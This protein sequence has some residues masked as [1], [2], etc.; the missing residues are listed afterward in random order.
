MTKNKK[1]PTR[2]TMEIYE[3]ARKMS[4]ELLNELN[5]IKPKC[6]VCGLPATR[7][8]GQLINF[9]YSYSFWCDKDEPKSAV[10]LKAT[11]VENAPTL[12][13]A[14]KWLEEHEKLREMILT[15]DLIEKEIKEDKLI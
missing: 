14:Y 4:C 7:E 2:P 5:K 12:R 10:N 1:N 11:D 13:R 9:K 6:H 3:E 8:A 15:L